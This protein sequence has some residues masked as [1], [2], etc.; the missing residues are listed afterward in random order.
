MFMRKCN[1]AGVRA[2]RDR[3]IVADR[4]VVVPIQSTTCTQGAI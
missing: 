2:G 1:D 3:V 4:D